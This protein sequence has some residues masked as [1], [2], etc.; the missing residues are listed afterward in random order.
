MRH[1]T[2]AQPEVQDFSMANNDKT[3]KLNTILSIQNNCK[4]KQ[5]RH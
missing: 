1:A 3:Q 2:L 5:K 4:I